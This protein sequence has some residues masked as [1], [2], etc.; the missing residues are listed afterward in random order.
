[1]PA[2]FSCGGVRRR[3]VPQAPWKDEVERLAASVAARWG[4]A[5]AGVEILGGGRRPLIRIS[6]EGEEP[7]TV[8]A[9]AGISEE[10][11]RALDLHDPIPHAYVLEVASPGLD[12]P[13]HSEGDFRRFAGRKIELVAREPVEGRR[14]WKGRLA[15]LEAGNVV[16][17][18]ENQLVRLPLEQVASA[19]LVVE[20]EDL[21]QDLAKGGRGRS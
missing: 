1:L 20:M 2:R 18:V 15:G 6:V 11:G 21:R 4:Y 10:L 19:R 14:R 5:L 17:D 3:F 9:C 13:L 12:R 7:V 8:D 16:V